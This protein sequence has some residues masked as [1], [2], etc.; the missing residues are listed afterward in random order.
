[1]LEINGVHLLIAVAVLF[2][3]IVARS[4]QW[5]AIAVRWSVPLPQFLM[6]QVLRK[7][8]QNLFK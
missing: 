3:F 8:D 6:A 4:V 7:R 2:M 5:M 1:M